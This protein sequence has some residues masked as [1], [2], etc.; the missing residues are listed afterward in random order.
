M[1]LLNMDHGDVKHGNYYSSNDE[2]LAYEKI[3]ALMKS[4]PIPDREV[5]GNLGLYLTRP[6]MA[7][8]LFMHNLYQ[9]IIHSHGV[10]MEFGVRWGQNLALFETFR[11]IYEPHNVSRKIIGFDTFSGFPTVAPEDG[12][13]VDTGVCN[14]TPG[15]ESQLEELLEAHEQLAPRSHLRKF[16][17]VKGDLIETLPQYLERHPET[18][19]ALAYID[20]DLYQ[21]TKRCLEL[22]RNRLAKGSIIAFDEL[23]MEEFPGETIAVMEVL[24]INNLKLVR[25]PIVPY[26][27]YAVME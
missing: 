4:S 6:S 7:R 10:I 25:D 13:M 14:V 1:K 19:I 18:I 22:I 24:G 17:L 11:T 26:Q 3:R 2:V 5:L 20:V 27:S 23:N 9:K 16:E 21:P 8:L 12:S 15:Y